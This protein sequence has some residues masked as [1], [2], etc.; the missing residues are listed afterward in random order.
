MSRAATRHLIPS[1]L[2]TVAML[3]ALVATP[4]AAQEAPPLGDDFIF[5]FDGPNV[6]LPRVDG[7]VVVDPLDQGGDNRVHRTQYANWV[8]SG[9]F[10][11]RDVGIDMT[12]NVSEE[13]H[14][15]DTL[16]V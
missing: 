12:A 16:Y 15:G 9:F 14:E 8:A 6:L 5:F 4:A 11:Q 2:V 3:M 1:C 13:A 10:F 7:Q